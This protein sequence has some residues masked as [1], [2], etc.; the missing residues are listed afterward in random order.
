GLPSSD[1]GALFAKM[2][3]TAVPPPSAEVCQ[4]EPELP[5]GTDSETEAEPALPPQANRNAEALPQMLTVYG[6]A[7][8]APT[9][10]GHTSTLHLSVDLD[11]LRG[12]ETGRY[13]TLEG[14]PISVAKARL[15]TCEAGIIPSIFDYTTGEA[16]E[17]GR[18]ARLP[19]AA[20]RRKLELEQPGG[21][22]WRGCSRPIQW[23]EAHHLVHWADGGE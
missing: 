3:T 10:H 1:T 9:R 18:T 7:P 8:R 13:P 5:A 4:T 14:R 12:E 22:A 15:L 23:T 16:I 6:A 19:N 21:C 2:L 17:L 11:T 20:L